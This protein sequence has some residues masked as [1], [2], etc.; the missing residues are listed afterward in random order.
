M[1]RIL[2]EPGVV[3]I[4]TFGL[5]IVLIWEMLLAE[6]DKSLGC[7]GKKNTREIWCKKKKRR[8]LVSY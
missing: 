4:R 8:M 7:L 6:I 5:G 3:K 1:R 2:T